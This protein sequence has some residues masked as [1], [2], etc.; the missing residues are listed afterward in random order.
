MENVINTLHIRNFKSIR[1][2]TL[3]PRRVNL[4]IGQPNVGKSTVLEA[5]SLLGGLPYAQHPKFMREFVRYEKPRHLFHDN[6]VDRTISVESD[7]EVCLFGPRAKGDGYHYASLSREAYQALGGQ[8]DGPTGASRAKQLVRTTADTAV[9]Q[10][11]RKQRKLAEGPLLDGHYVALDGK[12]RL[13]APW[14]LEAAETLWMPRPVK[15]YRF[16]HSTGLAARYADA[17]LR[18]PFGDNLVQVLETNAG[19]RHEF[20]R[21][22][23]VNGLNLRVRADTRRF[24]VVKDVDGL[25]YIYPY[26]GTADTLQRFGFYLAAMQSNEQ[27]VLL[28]EE[29]ESHS[30]PA[31]VTQLGERIAASSTNQYFITTHSPY[32]FSEVLDRMVPYENRGPELAVFVVYYESFETKVRELSDSEVRDIR[33]DA[34]DSFYN[35]DRFIHKANRKATVVTSGL[36]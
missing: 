14:S 2:A 9:L 16:S 20:T 18:P 12:G 23:A 19:L 33:H 30:Y 5:L 25:T 32:L 3:H 26:S 31:Y 10:A 1:N 21:L 28:F 4:I 22:F 17:A 24:E 27:S 34:F 13:E 29:P 8:A 15:S 6:I 7:R 11:F 35:L 36:N